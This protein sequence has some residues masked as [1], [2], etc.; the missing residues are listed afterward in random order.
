MQLT[1]TDVVDHLQQEGRADDARRAGTEL[2]E[3][4]DV[5]N[6]PPLL[7]ELGLD[8]KQ[9]LGTIGSGTGEE[10]GDLPV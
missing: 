10:P 7:D 8:A 5:E 4:F 6:P 2:P 1:R 9:L 3:S